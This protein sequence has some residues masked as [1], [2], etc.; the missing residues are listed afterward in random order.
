MDKLTIIQKYF[1]ALGHGKA[2]P[3]LFTKDAL[4]ISE[5]Y[6]ELPYEEY[7]RNLLRDES[8]MWLKVLHVFTCEDANILGLHIDKKLTASTGKE[9][10][11]EGFYLFE[12]E[13][14][15]IRRFT[16]LY[17]PAKVV[18]ALKE[19]TAWKKAA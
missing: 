2:A 3:E 16:N 4:V 13:G 19:Q 17:N 14:D 7:S 8:K 5:L 6:G 9:A 1:D 15:K 11:Y 18:E 10:E 12:F